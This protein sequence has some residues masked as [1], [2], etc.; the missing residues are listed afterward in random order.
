MLPR[1]TWSRALFAIAAAVMSAAVTDSIV[2]CLS[3]AGA[4]GAATFTDHSSLDIIPAL[5]VALILCGLIVAGIVRRTVRHAGAAPSWLRSIG[6]VA[7]ERRVAYILPAVLAIQLGA[8]WLMETVE[9]IA[10]AGHPLAGVLWLGGPI[11]VSLACH[12]LGC[13]ITTVL[14]GRIV[15]WSAQTVVKVIRLIRLWLCLIADGP[16]A[17][18]MHASIVVR[19]GTRAPLLRRLRGRA[20]PPLFA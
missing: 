7:R 6:E 5:S 15:R 18:H 14:L 13:V 11:A 20:P 16:S 9:Q 12:A 1:L 17:S 19:G 3:N 8:L 4:F 10:V 2:E